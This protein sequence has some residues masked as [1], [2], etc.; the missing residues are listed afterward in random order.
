M[1]NKKLV[2]PNNISQEASNAVLKIN[3]KR[4]GEEKNAKAILKSKND[5]FR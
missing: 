4:K 3:A 2:D 5:V 1:D